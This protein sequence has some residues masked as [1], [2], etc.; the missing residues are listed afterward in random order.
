MKRPM[1]TGDKGDVQ[2]EQGVFIPMSANDWDGSNGEHGLIMSLSTWHYVHLEA[3]VPISVYIYSV[4]AFLLMGG[5]G[6]R[7][8]RKAINAIPEESE[9]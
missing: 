8:I 9:V 4:L 5:V 7:L 1:G 2:F 6:V 3:P